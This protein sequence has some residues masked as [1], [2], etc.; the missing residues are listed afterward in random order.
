MPLGVEFGIV[1]D[2]GRLKLPS[3]FRQAMEIQKTWFISFGEGQTLR[4]RTTGENDGRVE[5]DAHGRLFIAPKF[6]A[7]FKATRVRLVWRKDDVIVMTSDDFEK[8]GDE[9]GGEIPSTLRQ[10]PFE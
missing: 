4:I 9:L 5:V 3:A 10:G 1:D 2:R 8:L 7:R 6:S